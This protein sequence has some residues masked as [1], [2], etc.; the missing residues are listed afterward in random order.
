VVLSQPWCA[1]Y[2]FHKAE[3]ESNHL[4]FFIA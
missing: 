2:L 1:I 3:E 4:F